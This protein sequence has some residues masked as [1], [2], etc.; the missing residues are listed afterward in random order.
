M[1]HVEQEGVNMS[2]EENADWMGLKKAQKQL[3]KV[4][5][6]VDEARDW[7][8]EFSDDDPL[9]SYSESLQELWKGLSIDMMFMNELV[10]NIK[11]EWAKRE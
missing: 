4:M 5:E 1:G 11:K 2:I 6:N 9:Y 10:D 7:L 3:K 8:G